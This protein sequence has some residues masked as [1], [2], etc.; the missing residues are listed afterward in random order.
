MTT[1]L[2]LQQSPAD[3]LWAIGTVIFYIVLAALWSLRGYYHNH[4]KTGEKWDHEEALPALLSGALIGTA[5]VWSGQP[6]TSEYVI[7]VSGFLIPFLD[8]VWTMVRTSYDTATEMYEEGES[9]STIAL[10]IAQIVDR[11]VDQEDVERVITEYER[12]F[13]PL[14][15]SR[16]NVQKRS[17]KLRDDYES[18][19]MEKAIDGAQQPG[20]DDT[21]V[22]E[23]VPD[24]DSEGDR[25]EL[26]PSAKAPDDGDAE[27]DDIVRDGP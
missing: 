16:E 13:G 5:V 25:Y 18:G 22:D 11:Q 27:D 7:A 9:I 12:R 20:P 17:E 3:V 4:K 21:R 1:E 15:P 14:D 23:P 8:K 26:E 19:G 2:L 6:L 10:E 24:V